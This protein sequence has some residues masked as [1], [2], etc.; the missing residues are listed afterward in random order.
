MRPHGAATT[1]TAPRPCCPD[2]DRHLRHPRALESKGR[3]GTER[4]AL[5]ETKSTNEA[6]SDRLK[7][8]A[9]SPSPKKE[10]TW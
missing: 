1:E 4:S 5:L 3:W 7:D 6:E 2:A 8:T 9:R 10:R